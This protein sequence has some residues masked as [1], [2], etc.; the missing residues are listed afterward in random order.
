MGKYHLAKLTHTEGTYEKAL[1]S[2]NKA[3]ELDPKNAAFIC[4]RAKLHAFFQRTRNAV[5]DYQILN[6]L[7][8]EQKGSSAWRD[9]HL[10][11][12]LKGKR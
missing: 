1:V 12:T 9:F 8:E 2:L 5:D 7:R 4:E 10:I 11:N 6:Q 3:L